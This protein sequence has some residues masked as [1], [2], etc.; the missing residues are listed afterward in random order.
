MKT[1]TPELKTL[2]DTGRYK[3]AELYTLTLA[4]GEIIRVGTLSGMAL[5]WGGNAFAPNGFNFER[6]TISSKLHRGNL[7]VDNVDMTIFY[8]A[9]NLL[10]GIPVPQ[11]IRNGGLNGARLLIQKAFCSVDAS[12]N[13]NPAVVWVIFL[14][15]GR[16]SKPRPGVR[17]SC[18]FTVIAD[19]EKLSVNVP[20]ETINLNCMNTH[21]DG[22]CGLSE[23]AFTHAA[24]ITSAS[25]TV[26]NTGLSQPDDYFSK[27][28][29]VSTSGE[30][31]GVMR[32]VKRFAGGQ[33]VLASPLPYQPAVGD[34]FDAIAGCDLSDPTC[35]GRFDNLPNRRAFKHIP[36]YEEN[37]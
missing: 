4:S 16:V 26:L 33:F 30:N 8:K 19:T 35:N 11:F 27:G 31:T 37:L 25:R 2:L 23:A 9:G 10:A 1:V 20:K 29:I 34:T 21:Y 18:S 14:F 36:V 6:G 15:E 32:T 12:N 28:R 5:N 3:Q 13:T 7:D 22:R 17:M 24:T